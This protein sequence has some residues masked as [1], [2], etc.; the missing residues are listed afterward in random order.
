MPE[1]NLR[2]DSTLSL[3]RRI[4]WDG[5]ARGPSHFVT[6][7]RSAP[8]PVESCP[9]GRSFATRPTASVDDGDS[10]IHLRDGQLRRW[11]LH[12]V[13]ELAR[14]LAVFFAEKMRRR[15]QPYRSAARARCPA[16]AAT[17]AACQ[18]AVHPV[19]I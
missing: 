4:G 16:A 3:W 1:K 14:F 8:R 17:G 9:P 13:D 15:R 6:A 10:G 5:I 7:P 2:R 11:V 18:P 19:W 12:L